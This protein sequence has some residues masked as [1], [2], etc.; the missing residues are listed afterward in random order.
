MSKLWHTSSYVH[1]FIHVP[2]CSSLF[3]YCFQLLPSV[4]NRFQLLPI[5]SLCIDPSITCFFSIVFFFGLSRR[6]RSDLV[7]RSVKITLLCGTKPVSKSEWLKRVTT[8]RLLLAM[9][10]LAVARSACRNQNIKFISFWGIFGVCNAA[11]NAPGCRT[12]QISRSNVQNVARSERFW[13]LRWRNKQTVETAFGK[14]NGMCTFSTHEWKVMASQR[15]RTHSQR[16]TFW[17]QSAR[18]NFAW[19]AQYMRYF[20]QAC[21]EVR[22]LISRESVRPQAS[23]CQFMLTCFMHD[24]RNTSHDQ[25]SLYDNNVRTRNG[26]TT[27]PSVAPPFPLY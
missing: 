1:L 9:V 26:K 14:R 15:S 16:E 10:H 17:S 24:M 27:G 3:V 23:T 13:N 7:Q 20:H 6:K 8:G 12:K 18:M 2:L 19:G 21:W 11:A 5:V 4:S 25:A 22:A